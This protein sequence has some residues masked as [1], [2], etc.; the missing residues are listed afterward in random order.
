MALSPACVAGSDI[1]RHAAS[2][3]NV[4]YPTPFDINRNPGAYEHRR[5]T[6]VGWLNYGFERRH[7]IAINSAGNSPE[8]P[9]VEGD[10]IS[11]EV[12]EAMRAR[13]TALRGSNV[14]V[15]GVFYAD[16]AGH[17]V[18]FGFCSLSGLRVEAIDPL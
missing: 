11:V 1:S 6:V 12:P 2:A 10:C 13:A 16:L 5:I 3:P 14:A 4:A 17:S 15:T 9:A 18:A 7:L 8:A